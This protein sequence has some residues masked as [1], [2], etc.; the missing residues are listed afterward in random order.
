MEKIMLY[1]CSAE[2]KGASC[3]LESLLLSPY[4]FFKQ[5]NNSKTATTQTQAFFKKPPNLYIIFR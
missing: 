3:G 4:A 1:P 2:T 5:L